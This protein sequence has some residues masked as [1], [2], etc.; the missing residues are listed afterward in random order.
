MKNTLRRF[1]KN[2]RLVE[3]YLMS[4]MTYSTTSNI[5]KPISQAKSKMETL[6][7]CCQSTVCSFTSLNSLTAEST[8][9]FFLITHQRNSTRRSMSSLGASF[10]ALKSQKTSTHSY[11]LVSII[12]VPSKLRVSS[13]GMEHNEYPLP[14]IHFYS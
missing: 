3:A 12:C 9:G 11:F 10:I 1:S 8:S 14:H 7:S 2:S 4:M 5:S 6:C 13:S